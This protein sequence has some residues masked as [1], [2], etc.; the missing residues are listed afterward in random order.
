MLATCAGD[1][2]FRKG[3][4]RRWPWR[5]NED[6]HSCKSATLGKNYFSLFLI[7]RVLN[8]ERFFFCFFSFSD[9]SLSLWRCVASQM[10]ESFFFRSSAFICVASP[11]CSTHSRFTFP[12]CLS[13]HRRQPG[14]GGCCVPANEANYFPHQIF[15]PFFPPGLLLH[16]P[17][18]INT[19]ILQPS[20]QPL[21]P[22]TTTTTTTKSKSIRRGVWS[23][24]PTDSLPACC[25][26]FRHP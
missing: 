26:A 5:R 15:S 10:V 4:T 20:Q 25:A 1:S 23:F 24:P 13:P 22:S 21:T 3:R 16:F 6:T 19:H 9:G 17:Q 11:F 12:C 7:F 8:L 18:H 2:S 14:S